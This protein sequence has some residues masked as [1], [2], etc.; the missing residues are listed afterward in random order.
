MLSSV[1]GVPRNV[2]REVG[3]GLRIESNSFTPSASFSRSMGVAELAGTSMSSATISSARLPVIWPV[4]PADRTL[5]FWSGSARA[6]SN[7]IFERR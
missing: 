7:S 5:G 3:R 6:T 1:C 2:T 4:M